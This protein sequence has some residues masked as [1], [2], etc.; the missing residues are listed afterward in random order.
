MYL[1]EVQAQIKKKHT[2]HQKALRI[3]YFAGIIPPYFPHQV[4]SM[5]QALQKKKKSIKYKIP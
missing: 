3:T 2:S 1:P 5:T 4:T